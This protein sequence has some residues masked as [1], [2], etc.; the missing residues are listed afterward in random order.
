MLRP[1]RVIAMLGLLIALGVATTAAAE[2]GSSGCT[3]ENA[4]GPALAAP[5]NAPKAAQRKKAAR[6]TLKKLKALKVSLQADPQS[7]NRTVNLGSD[8]EAEEI[9]LRVNVSRVVP[10]NFAEVLDIV[11]EPFI[12]TSE[13]GD[14]VT[15][16]EPTFSEP[17]LSG[18]RKRI[19]FKMCIN[20]PNDLPAGKYVSTVMLEGPPAVEGA[21]MTVTLNAKDGGRFLLAAGAAA[22]IAFLVLLYKGAGEKRAASIAEAEK[23]TDDEKRKQEVKKAENWCEATKRCFSDVGWMIPTVASVAAAFALLYAAYAD[24]PA[25]GEGGLVS[26]AIALI[27]TGL[28]AVGVRTVFTQAPAGSK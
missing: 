25:W 23:E 17:R 21:V 6:Q 16:S 8:R 20:P 1:A 12:S 27:G 4:A 15:F 26:S 5:A 7:A 9:P 19:T 24:N 11:A 14:T 10:K 28:A 22:L 2:D 13:T 3:V 18:N